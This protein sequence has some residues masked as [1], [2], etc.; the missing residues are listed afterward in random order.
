M[1]QFKFSNLGEIKICLGYEIE[2]PLNV[3]GIFRGVKKINDHLW[4][5]MYIR[6]EDYFNDVMCIREIPLFK[7]KNIM[8]IEN[9]RKLKLLYGVTDHYTWDWERRGVCMSNYDEGNF[10]V[11]NKDVLPV[12]FTEIEPINIYN[13]DDI[14]LRVE[15]VIVDRNLKRVIDAIVDEKGVSE[16]MYEI[17]RYYDLC[18]RESR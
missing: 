7:D 3:K 18:Y 1:K 15:M 8:I 13:T 14:S 6:D 10:I 16:I 2:L 11:K 12:N 17:Q 5:L 9:N 4:V